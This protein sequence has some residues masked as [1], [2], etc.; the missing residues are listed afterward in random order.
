MIK[1]TSLPG[2]QNIKKGSTNE[3]LKRF[4]LFKMIFME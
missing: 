2:I 3:G 1:I 4:P